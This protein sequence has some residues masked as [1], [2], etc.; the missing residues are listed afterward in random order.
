MISFDTKT[1]LDSFIDYERILHEVPVS[2]F[3]LERVT[4]LLKL[5]GNPQE[6]LK[7]IHVAGSK[8][9]GSTC[10]LTASI[11]SQGGY[12]VGLYTS[13]H[14]YSHHERIRILEKSSLKETPSQIFSDAISEEELAGLFQEMEISVKKMQQQNRWGLLSFFE[15]LTCAALLHFYKQ[16]VD[17]VVLETGL[18]GRLDATNAVSSLICAITPISLE[19]T[20]ILGDTLR[21]IAAEKAAII[22]QKNQKVIIAPQEKGVKNFFIRRCQA[23]NAIALFVDN[24]VTI[25]RKLSQDNKQI[26]NIITPQHRYCDLTLSLLGAYQCVNAAMAICVV[27]ALKLEGFDVAPEAIDEGLKKVFWPGRCEIIQSHP[28]VVLDGAHNQASTKSLVQTLNEISL[29][30]KVFLVLGISEDKDKQSI[31]QELYPITQCIIATKADHPR[32]AD[33]SDQEL[34]E[35]FPGKESVMTSNVQEAL[36]FAFDQAQKDDMILVTG[37]LFVVSEARKLCQQLLP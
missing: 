24:D 37:S 33:F 18:G 34:K 35:F 26:V 7:I 32:A 13:P 10:A 5:L 20:R 27:E 19:H 6:H 28:T 21:A 16:K 22:K 2:S 3:K 25:E 30:R 4:H 17:V 12:R 29:G 1:Y 23:L 14:L 15:I 31:C 11:L 36:Q 8:G 9:K